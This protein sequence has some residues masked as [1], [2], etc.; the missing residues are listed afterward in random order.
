MRLGA[1]A[2]SLIL[3]PLALGA[4]TPEWIWH[5]Q[6]GTQPTDHEV[7]FF[8]K[9][10]AVVG[11]PRQAVLAL[12][13]DN[14]AVA[15]LNGRRAA[16]SRGWEHAVFADVT[17]LMRPGENLLAI[18]GRNESGPAALLGARGTDRRD[19]AGVALERGGD[20]RD[21]EPLLVAERDDDGA[22]VDPVE[23]LVGP[24]LDHLVGA[25]DALGSRER[26]PSIDHR[27]APPELLPVGAEVLGRLRTRD[28]RG[29]VLTGKPLVFAVG[30]DITQFPGITPERARE[31]AK[32][33]HELF[34]RLRELPFPT[35]A[36]VNG[37]ALGPSIN[38]VRAAP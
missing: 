2:L 20:G 22:I 11:R 38:V 10:F 36:A 18:R 6:P 17:R 15:Y 29:L 21:V 16:V 19:V 34:G 1:A 4:Q 23:H 25:R 30:A 8:R 5:D 14:Y 24:G 13:G 27:R 35:L 3:L 37:A 9:T 12:A 33:G 7:R 31:G 26:G 28:W 32:A